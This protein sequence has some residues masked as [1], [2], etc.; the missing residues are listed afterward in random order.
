[1]NKLSSFF[2]YLFKDHPG[3]EPGKRAPAI[4]AIITAFLA[5]AGP[6]IQ[7]GMNPGNILALIISIVVFSWALRQVLRT[8]YSYAAIVPLTGALFICF[9][10]LRDGTG[11]HSPAWFG[12]AGATLLLYLFLDNEVLAFWLSLVPLGLFMFLGLAEMNGIIPDPEHTTAF[13]LANTVMTEMLIS[14]LA[15]YIFRRQRTLLRIARENEAAKEIANTALRELNQHL[16]FRVANRT[17]DLQVASQVSREVTSV[18]DL[19]ELLPDLVEKT[20]EGYDLYFVSVYLFD[21]RQNQLILKSG[22]GEAGIQM[23]GIRCDLSTSQGYVARSGREAQPI[24]IT[25][26]A[27]SNSYIS[28]PFLPK[29][30]S[31]AA[32][33]MI[34][35]AKLIGVLDLQSTGLDSFSAEDIAVMTTLAEQIGVAIQNAALFQEQVSVAAE[36]RRVDSMKTQFLASMSHELRTPLNATIN[37]V[38][39]A[40]M[41]VGGTLTEKQRELLGNSLQ[42]SR[43]LLQL[44]NDVL[45]ISKI[46]AGKLSLFVE[47]N[48][49]IYTEINSVVELIRPRLKDKPIELI[50]D[51][52]DNLPAVEVDRR[53]IRQI[54]LNLLVNAVKFTLQG[55]ITLSA[56]RRS[57]S[58]L[59][60]VTDTGPGISFDAQEA[61]FEP[62]VQ[63]ADGVK[64]VEG[65]GLGLSISRSLAQAHGGRLWV[66]SQPGEGAAF[67]F[68]LPWKS[69]P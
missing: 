42:S 43:H 40:L 1:M 41:G 11:T 19:E 53:R 32:I 67:Y 30:L 17:R 38:E 45:D 50:L 68:E 2:E 10:S 33:T 34:V 51:I 16:E 44:I 66:E 63:T 36:L 22:T 5:A 35:Q 69:N 12:A 37:F 61:I 3:D 64:Q 54:F 58:I 59:F 23:K 26:T 8:R 56:K 20:R 9:Q 4:I 47:S 18:L 60:A 7:S 29:T 21:A 55:S 39:L 28:N 52:D 24:V 62:F 49:S 6:F 25:D 15:F 31:A 65:T 27:R 14:V 46:Q 57:E 13:F 48:V